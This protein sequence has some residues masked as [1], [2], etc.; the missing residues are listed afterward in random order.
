[1]KRLPPLEHNSYALSLEQQSAGSE[2]SELLY[3]QIRK[4]FGAAEYVLSATSKSDGGE[5]AF[6]ILLDRPSRQITQTYR[7]VCVFIRMVSLKVVIA[8]VLSLPRSF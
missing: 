7:P 8:L 1:M 2:A 6:R 5:K 4:L 3:G